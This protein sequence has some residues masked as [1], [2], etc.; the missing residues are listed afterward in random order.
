MR[1]REALSHPRCRQ[2]LRGKL[3]KGAVEAITA[4]ESE[5]A[6]ASK[7]RTPYPTPLLRLFGDE[8]KYC[9]LGIVTEE[10]L[11]E[12]ALVDRGT[13]ERVVTKIT[14]KSLPV[15]L[16]VSAF[17]D[18]VEHTRQRVRAIAGADMS[19]Q[20]DTV[21]QGSGIEGHPDARTDTDVFEVKTSGRVGACWSEFLMQVFAYA[22]LDDRVERVH[23]VLPL[24]ELVW[25][26]DVRN[27]WPKRR[28]Y[29]EALEAFAAKE[30]A[31]STEGAA[32][33][34]GLTLLTMRF[35]IG[36]HVRKQRRI[37]DTLKLIPDPS[38]P[39]QIFLGNPSSTRVSIND[40]DLSEA[41]ELVDQHRLRIYIHAPYL[42]NL[43]ARNEYNVPCLIKLLQAGSAFGSRGVVVHVGK[44]TTQTVETA[45]DNMRTNIREVLEHATP[46]CPLLLETPAGQGTELLS[47]GPDA[48]M[49]F[50]CDFQDPR[51]AACVDTCHVFATGFQPHA[52]L[53]KIVEHET[54]TSYLQLV[55]FNDSA[56]PSG[57]RVDRHAPPGAGYVGAE[58]MER[59][60]A[61][62]SEYNLPLIIE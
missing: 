37:A 18:R 41:L 15:K 22:A 57:S 17:L 54:W 62:A 4:E 14:G 60:A 44:S 11:R 25:T 13:L 10:L 38:R 42:I 33:M 59:C 20:Y 29:R 27:D 49:T 26:W 58:E 6:A 2:A 19:L 30:T 8:A 35:P 7:A 53:K 39:Y 55:H 1:V 23:L 36:H 52:Y 40:E 28:E 48:F 46:E 43:A 31:R 61:L 5:V 34:F 45:L 32:N 50:V 12:D 51:F 21:V 16:N 47:E 3:P 9:T 24:Q 56:A